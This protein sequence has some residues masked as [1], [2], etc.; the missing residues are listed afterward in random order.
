MSKNVFYD[1]VKIIKRPAKKRLKSFLIFFT[2][3]IVFAV[4]ILASIGLSN[5]ITVG[6]ISSY[7]IFGDSKFTISAS[8][9]YAITLGSYD[10]LGDAEK[11]AYGSMVQGAS[12]YIWESDKFYVIGNIYTTN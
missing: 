11:V 6:N 10:N 12:G 7:L 3:I 1:D 8:E 5:A 9:M 2:I 4:T